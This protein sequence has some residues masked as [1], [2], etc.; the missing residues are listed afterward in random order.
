MLEWHDTHTHRY[1][2]H[3]VAETI[4]YILV[5]LFDYSALV[6]VCFGGNWTKFLLHK[7]PQCRFK[8]R[9]NFFSFT[10]MYRAHSVL[11]PIDMRISDPVT[12]NFGVVFKSILYTIRTEMKELESEKHCEWEKKKLSIKNEEHELCHLFRSHTKWW[13]IFPGTEPTVFYTTFGAKKIFSDFS[14]TNKIRD[15]NIVSQSKSHSTSRSTSI[16]TEKHS[17]HL[18]EDVWSKQKQ[19][20]KN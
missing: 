1:K 13:T 11:L 16:W 6:F 3:F 15:K 20:Q 18:N 17:K 9:S 19:K 7:H 4:K 8:R 5:V 2:N 14:S 12:T 10:K